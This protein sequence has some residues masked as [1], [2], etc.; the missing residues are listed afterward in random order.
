MPYNY[1]YHLDPNPNLIPLGSVIFDPI[2]EEYKSRIETEKMLFQQKHRKDLIRSIIFFV[3][4]LLLIV[5]GVVLWLKVSVIL[6]FLPVFIAIPFLIIAIVSLISCA[7]FRITGIKE[8]RVT[9]RETHQ[10]YVDNAYDMPVETSTDRVTLR[11][12]DTGKEVSVA[13]DAYTQMHCIEGKKVWLLKTSKGP[14]ISF[15]E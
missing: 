12:E 1:S 11:I 4:S 6:L 7:G 2:T 10:Y 9:H 15:Y 14:V 5:L 3:I 8:C 13:T